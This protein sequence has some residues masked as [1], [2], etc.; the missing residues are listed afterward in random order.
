MVGS[1]RD[2]ACYTVAA[3]AAMLSAAPAPAAEIKVLN[4]NA[5]TIAMKAIAADF[6]KE[7]GHHRQLRRRLARAGRAAAQG[8]RGLRPRHHRDRLGCRLSRRTANGAPAPARRWRGSASGLRCARA[9]KLD[10]STVESTRKA[11]LDAKSITYSDSRTGGLSGPNAQ[12]VLVNLGIADAVKAKPKLDANGQE[13]IAKGEIDIGLYNVSEI[14]RAQGRGAGRPGA[15][16]GAGLHQLRLGDRRRP[17]RRPTTALALLEF[18][19]AR[20]L[21]PGL[22]QGRAGTVAGVI[23]NNSCRPRAARGRR[24]VRVHAVQFGFSNFSTNSSTGPVGRLTL[25]SRVSSG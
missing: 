11:L 19:T 22:G 20:S 12:K 4:A 18:F 8:R 14:P 17:T 5:L 3:A 6:T 25:K 23:R 2:C 21:A 9:S 7:T 24:R 10:L 16:R 13:L 1:L 15:G